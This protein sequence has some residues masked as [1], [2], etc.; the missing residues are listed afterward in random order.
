MRFQSYFVIIL[1]IINGLSQTASAQTP[2][3]SIL[4]GVLTDK[5]TGEPLPFA[6]VHLQDSSLGCTT[7]IDG[8]F[9]IEGLC[10]GEHRLVFHYLGYQDAVQVLDIPANKLVVLDAKLEEDRGCDCAVIVE[11]RPL[12]HLASSETLQQADLDRQAGKTLAEML[13]S[14]TGVSLLQSGA[15][16]SKPVVHGLFGNRL[17][18]LNNGV[19]QEGQQWGN[20]HALE[21]DPFSAATIS[22]VKGAAGVQ[23]GTDA[24]GGVILVQPKAL[25]QKKGWEGD[26]YAVLG[27]NGRLGALSARL[28]AALPLAAE[29]SL[30]WRLQATAKRAGNYATP[31]YL[32]ANTGLEEYNASTIFQYQTPKHRLELYYSLF[33]TRLGIFRGSHIGNLTD[34]YNAFALD[35][36]FY[37]T[38]QFSYKIGRPAQRVSHHLAKINYTYSIDKDNKLE[39][40]AAFQYNDRSE[41]DAHRTFGDSLTELTRPALQLNI[42]T[43]S[44]DAHWLHHWAE[45]WHGKMGISTQF[46][47]NT[48]TGTQSFIPNYYAA[49]AGAF[50]WE[51]YNVDKWQVEM[52]LRYDFKWME[53]AMYRMDTI[54]R[55]AYLFHNLSA[56]AG[57]R[58]NPFGAFYL[59]LY[60]GTAWRAP[61][62]N[63]LFSEGV[64]HSAASYEIGDEHLRPEKAYNGVLA[65]DYSIHKKLSITASGYVN[66]I[67][68]F[69]YT[70]A[71][72]PATL[73]IRGAFPTFR[74]TQTNALLA[75]ADARLRYTFWRGLGVESR[76]SMVRG[77]HLAAADF[78]PFMPADRLENGLYYNYENTRNDGA[79]RDFFATITV[80]TVFQQ[81]YAPEASDYLAPPRGYTLLGTQI[82]AS[83]QKNGQRY[84]CSLEIGNLL[85]TTYRDYLDRFRYYAD[86]I[87]R[88]ITLRLKVQFG[89]E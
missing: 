31:H 48:N 29:R 84:Q 74:Y 66:Y 40:T 61:A 6:A 65:L 85:N 21:L 19:R 22:V 54:Y 4:R 24:I 78:L 79:F 35:T 38:Q 75:G 11:A 81:K 34:L 1:F 32:L 43:Y 86:A 36:P 7:N 63:E 70:Q 57:A 10:P 68:D 87:G 67:Q 47:D 53:A 46:Q 33:Y 56:T 71:V 89:A 8:E 45:G 25:R 73:T 3:T 17:L 28:E 83:F 2:C 82:G 23:Y 50:W 80:R 62:P 60:A 39:A 51:R 77:Y 5:A 55:P 20:E 13:A 69:I 14:T 42:K 76:Y 18:L 49:T 58:Y 41:Y 30:A 59:S 52:G 12:Q 16:I 64:H 37:A 9:Q 88:T 44:L 72:F 26:L 15:T 27:V